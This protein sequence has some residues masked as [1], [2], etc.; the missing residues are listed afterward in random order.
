M[1]YHPPSRPH[2]VYHYPF[3]LL[4][5][6]ILPLVASTIEVSLSL[7]PA[8]LYSRLHP[9]G[10][11]ASNDKFCAYERLALNWSVLKVP[12]DNGVAFD[13]PFDLLHVARMELVKDILGDLEVQAVP[14][15]HSEDQGVH[16]NR[17]EK[18]SEPVGD[19]T[20]SLSCD[21]NGGENGQKR[22]P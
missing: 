1:E 9:P 19:E 22:S 13:V 18:S 14:L 2:T 16:V 8:F 15:G 5:V 20:V 3:T 11:E 21:S 4:I 6:I 7:P 17:W 12:V 10:S